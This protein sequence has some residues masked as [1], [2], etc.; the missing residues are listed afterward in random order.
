M[1]DTRLSPSPAWVGA[2]SGPS[3]QLCSPSWG[4]ENQSTRGFGH[5]FLLIQT[6]E[7]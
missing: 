5:L 3:Q 7:V 4:S 6:V 2:P 1:H